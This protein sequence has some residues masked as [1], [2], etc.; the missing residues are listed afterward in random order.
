MQNPRMAS[1]NP[2]IRSS[3]MFHHDKSQGS[4]RQPKKIATYISIASTR[5]ICPAMTTAKPTNFSERLTPPSAYS[6]LSP[7]AAATAQRTPAGH[8]EPRRSLG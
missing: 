2:Q 6:P 1:V 5:N 3:A 7:T 8:S 4:S